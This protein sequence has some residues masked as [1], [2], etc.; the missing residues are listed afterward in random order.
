MG[1]V[2][3]IPLRK[4]H[5]DAAGVNGGDVVEVRIELDTDVRRVDPPAD[6]ESALKELPDGWSR[7]QKLSY[8]HQRE[9][10]EAIEGAKKPETRQRRIAQALAKVGKKV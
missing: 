6:L 4:S 2:V 9:F 1:G 10:V 5:R 7:W 3:C 8:T